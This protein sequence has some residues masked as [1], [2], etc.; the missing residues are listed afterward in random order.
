MERGC[1]LQLGTRVSST[2]ATGGSHRG[3]SSKSNPR[4]HI[5]SG[6]RGRRRQSRRPRTANSTCPQPVTVSTNGL[7]HLQAKRSWGSSQG[8]AQGPTCRGR[9]QPSEAQ[10]LKQGADANA[11]GLLNATW[12]DPKVGKQFLPC[13]QARSLP[14][15]GQAMWKPSRCQLALQAPSPVGATIPLQLWVPLLGRQAEESRKCKGL[16]IPHWRAHVPVKSGPPMSPPL[17]A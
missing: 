10:R 2:R 5:H 13:S 1:P 17:Y 15:L 4:P 12:E 11:V 16:C 3:A 14:W 6:F 8:Q 7:P 9:P